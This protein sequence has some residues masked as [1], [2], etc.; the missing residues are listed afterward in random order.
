M[1]E[2]FKDLIEKISRNLM[3]KEE[4]IIVKESEKE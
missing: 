3:K 1:K 2:I 4:I